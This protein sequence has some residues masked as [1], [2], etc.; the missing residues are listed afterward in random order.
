[1]PIYVS[2]D[3][4][5]FLSLHCSVLHR[6]TMGTEIDGWLFPTLQI[7]DHK[8]CKS[9]VI[10]AKNDGPWI[11]ANPWKPLIKSLTALNLPVWNA[12]GEDS[13][14]H[15]RGK[16]K[17]TASYEGVAQCR[18]HDCYPEGFLSNSKWQQIKWTKTF[19]SRSLKQSLKGDHSSFRPSLCPSAK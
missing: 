18:L 5:P 9:S 6:F 15:G 16:C 17:A 1:M 8:T 2:C 11:P 13:G 12:F 4:L 7:G 14:I 3:S 10:T 19:E